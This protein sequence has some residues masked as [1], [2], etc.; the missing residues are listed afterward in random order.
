MLPR[1]LSAAVMAFVPAAQGVPDTESFPLYAL[2]MIGFSILYMTVS[3]YLQQRRD[4]VRAEAPAPPPLQDAAQSPAP[5][6][7]PRWAVFTELDGALLDPTTFRYDES[8]Q[9]L[10]PS[11]RTA[12]PW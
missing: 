5:P 12:C 6:R 9:A 7:A 11:R 2:L 4:T 10:D 3:L 8:R 1:G